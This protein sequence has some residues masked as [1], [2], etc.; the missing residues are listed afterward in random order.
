[1]QEVFQAPQIAAGRGGETMLAP[2][3]VRR[4]LALQAPGWG[5]KRIRLQAGQRP[6]R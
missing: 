1:M 2:Q 4:M 6:P 3:E 5:A